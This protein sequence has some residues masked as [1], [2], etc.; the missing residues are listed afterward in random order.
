[1]R[2]TGFTLVET[3]LALALLGTLTLAT[4]SW[5][6]ATLRLRTTAVADQI[7]VQDIQTFERLLAI[8]LINQDLLGLSLAR[9]ERR[10]WVGQDALHVLTRDAGP[11]EVVYEFDHDRVVRRHRPLTGHGST[12]SVV[13]LEGLEACEVT[14]E[15]DER[16]GWGKLVVS[17]R[18]AKSRV[19]RL[20]FPVPAEWVR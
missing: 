8:D 17:I 15:I 11:A 6:T 18:A 9:R 3:V 14:I 4:V 2:R 13:I 10:V 19:T 20:T 5:A 1:M 7:T 12:D 16:L